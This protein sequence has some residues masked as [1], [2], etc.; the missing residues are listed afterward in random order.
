M[1]VNFDRHAARQLSQNTHN[2][3]DSKSGSSEGRRAK[4][5]GHHGVELQRQARGERLR[6][7]WRGGEAPGRRRGA[8]D[9]SPIP[10]APTLDPDE[11]IDLARTTAPLTEPTDQPTQEH[12]ENFGIAHNYCAYHTRHHTFPDT[13]PHKVDDALDALRERLGIHAQL[14]KQLAL[15][16]L[17]ARFRRVEWRT[18]TPD[19]HARVISLLLELSRNPLRTKYTHID[20]MAALGEDDLGTNDDDGA[21][22]PDQASDR[23]E[24]DVDVDDAPSDSTL[25]DWTDDEEQDGDDDDDDARAERLRLGVEEA[26]AARR[27]APR[28]GERVRGRRS[29]APADGTDEDDDGDDG[30]AGDGDEAATDPEFR[31]S[32]LRVDDEPACA[33]PDR[34]EWEWDPRATRGRSRGG[35]GDAV[36]AAA[37]RLL[38]ALASAR[39]REGA[40]LVGAWDGSTESKVVGDALH[41]LQGAAPA[42]RAPGAA[43]PH[44]SPAALAAGLERA[45][46]AAATLDLVERAA[47]AALA[48]PAPVVGGTSAELARR[49]G[50]G[51]H[52]T[53]GSVGF[54]PTIRAFAAALARHVRELRE[55]LA[56][57]V[58]RAAGLAA[59]GAGDKAGAPTLLELR[60]AVRSV[61]ARARVLDSLA[62]A[63]LPA[64]LAT[65]FNAGGETSNTG[66]GFDSPAVNAARCLTALHRACAA[67]QTT[68]SGDGFVASLRLL[69]SAAQ[70]Y[71]SALHRWLDRG[72]VGSDAA[73]GGELFV[74][75]GPEEGVAAIGT[76]AHWEGGFV[77]RR[78]PADGSATCPEFLARHVDELLAAGKSVRLLRSGAGGAGGG[79]AP[80]MESHL[81]VDFCDAVRRALETSRAPGDADAG[82]ENVS[83]MENSAAED[84]ESVR[85]L[86]GAALEACPPPRADDDTDDT[87][88]RA[89]APGFVVG[90]GMG[91]DAAAAEAEALVAAGLAGS[92][93]ALA[94]FVGE[95]AEWGGTR[96]DDVPRSIAA[97]AELDAW[98]RTSAD[99]RSPATCPAGALIARA[100]VAP[101]RARAA[102]A[103]SALMSRLREDWRL[104]AHLAALRAVFLG[105]AGEAAHSFASSV[106][107]RLDETRAGSG[108]G[109]EASSGESRLL[110]GFADA[111]EINAALA[112]ALAADGCGDLPDPSDV[113]VDVT[114]PQDV[115]PT[116]HAGAVGS[117]R[118]S[119]WGDAGGVGSSSAGEGAAMLDALS[120]LRLSVKTPWPLALVVPESCADRYNACATFLLQLRRARASVEEASRSGWTPAARRASGSVSGG[121][122]ARALLAELRHF[123]QAL[124]EHVIG[125]VL[126]H[127]WLELERD[128]ARATSAEEARAAHDRFLDKAQA[129]CLASP[130]PTWTLLAGQTRAALG[131]ACDFAAAQ[132]RAGWSARAR[133]EGWE[134]IPGPGYYSAAEAATRAG[135]APVPEGEAERLAGAFRRARSYVLRVIESKLRVGTYPELHE[136]RLRLDFNGYY[137]T[138]A[139]GES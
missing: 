64:R 99:A 134:A 81:C 53:L 137:G 91:T 70:P 95:R 100:A 78:N 116:A 126:H 86:S 17:V 11:K 22:D 41:A 60:A 57:L 28:R 35:A 133:G 40:T 46:D 16:M 51:H 38:P 62:A 45:A 15:D 121:P 30:D 55:E 89:H 34:D 105:G 88:D 42:R 56:P 33:A 8:R 69:C 52:P 63:A 103:G 77:L 76:E 87:D 132:R 92:T 47:N 128:V 36:V 44:L 59:G 13:D 21:S 50:V 135:F 24:P 107:E 85:L 73:C 106:F 104:G 20:A 39:G 127:A 98:L 18:D 109:D 4:E 112:D 74:C 1:S 68:S 12:D 124:H 43:T 6:A 97:A 5:A 120:R 114:P 54:G 25:S 67:H 90:A 26:I 32:D 125:R 130:D 115:D 72:E 123:T 118:R 131:I 93:A 83:G 58:Q 101:A 49:R 65:G 119:V 117:R 113:A 10:P 29:G 96:H 111:S 102:A 48:T 27:D 71:L 19:V 94:P 61:A 37:A 2:A 9:P 82:K 3:P 23:D 80:K 122:H 7:A 136:L 84:D 75:A 14:D 139:G 108:G 31:W 129:Q 66:G 79:R 110:F 138:D